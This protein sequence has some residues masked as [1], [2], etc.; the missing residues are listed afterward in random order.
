MTK[1]EGLKSGDLVR[2]SYDFYNKFGVLMI[3]KIYTEGKNNVMFYD[4]WALK[5]QKKYY[6]FSVTYIKKMEI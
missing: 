6:K 5:D 3:L 1:D 2:W 4:L